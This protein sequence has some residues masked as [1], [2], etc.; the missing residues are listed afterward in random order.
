MISSIKTWK[1]SVMKPWARTAWERKP[2]RKQLLLCGQF[3]NTYIHHTHSRMALS[4]D[5]KTVQR[6]ELYRWKKIPQRLDVWP[7]AVL[8]LCWITI[9]IPKLD[10]M[11]SMIVF[12]VIGIIHIL[13]FLFETW[14]VE[15]RCFVQAWK[16]HSYIY[17]CI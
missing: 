10:F 5:G 12:G 2:W 16:V 17:I 13:T 4:V 8:Y 15:F 14:S 7:F 6:I 9:L 11:D 1:G 3:G